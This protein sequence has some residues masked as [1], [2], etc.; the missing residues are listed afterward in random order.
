[1]ALAGS[2]DTCLGWHTFW[3]RLSGPGVGGRATDGVRCRWTAGRV[4]PPPPPPLRR[5]FFVS[6][7]TPLMAL[8]VSRSVREGQRAAQSV[9]DRR[10]P[11]AA[12]QPFPDGHPLVAGGAPTP[13]DRRRRVNAKRNAF[14]GESAD[15]DRSCPTTDRPR[16]SLIHI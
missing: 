15:S 5:W 12:A 3:G 7:A 16:L 9:S 8:I 11:A 1:M 6:V 10:V 14:D 13:P 2:A 4:P